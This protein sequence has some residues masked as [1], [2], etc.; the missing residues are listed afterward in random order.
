MTVRE[1]VLL[2]HMQH[3]AHIRMSAIKQ[4]TAKRLAIGGYGRPVL[5]GIMLP[6]SPM[7]VL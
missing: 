4:Q 6:M 3:K 7:T 2:R 5:F 1:D